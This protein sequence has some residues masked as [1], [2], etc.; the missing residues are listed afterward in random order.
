M[1]INRKINKII[2]FIIGQIKRFLTTQNNFDN[3]SKTNQ[4]KQ[5][6]TKTNNPI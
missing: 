6:K 1:I 4:K 5:N 2:N 3:K